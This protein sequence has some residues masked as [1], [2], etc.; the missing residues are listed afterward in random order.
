MNNEGS[1]KSSLE[2]GQHELSFSEGDLWQELIDFLSSRVPFAI[3]RL[4]PADQKNLYTRQPLHNIEK[5]FKA[6]PFVED[7]QINPNE[8]KGGVNICENVVYGW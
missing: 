5:K 6:N 1:V 7:Y 4:L 3:K 2:T 8:E